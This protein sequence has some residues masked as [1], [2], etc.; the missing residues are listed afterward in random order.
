MIVI[1]CKLL[2]ILYHFYGGL[3]NLVSDHEGIHTVQTY[4]SEVASDSLWRVGTSTAML[5]NFSAISLGI[6]I[7]IFEA[8][9]LNVTQPG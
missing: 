8:C 9:G 2:A 1:L 3:H 6:C 7:D 4:F 5:Q